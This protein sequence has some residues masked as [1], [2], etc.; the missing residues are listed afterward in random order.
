VL[1]GFRDQDHVL[2]VELEHRLLPLSDPHLRGAR[3][4]GPFA[5]PEGAYATLDVARAARERAG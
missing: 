1:F 2:V 4:V 5:R 3:L